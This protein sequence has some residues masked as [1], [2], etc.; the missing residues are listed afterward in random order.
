LVENPLARALL[1]GRFKP[2]TRI[3]V[4]AD[5]AGGTLVFTDGGDAI[6]TTSADDRRDARPR[7]ERAPAEPVAAPAGGDGSSRLN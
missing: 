4:D 3:K 1:E 2:G 7:V 6:V 5:L